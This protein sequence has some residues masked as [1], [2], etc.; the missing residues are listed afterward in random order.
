MG[1]TEGRATAF[2]PVIP[3]YWRPGAGGKKL[4]FYVDRK[5]ICEYRYT[6]NGP[7]VECEN[8]AS[9]FVIIPSSQEGLRFGR[10]V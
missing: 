2:S 10:S 3:R 5:T 8:S 1:R 9:R 7:L 4:I 6:C